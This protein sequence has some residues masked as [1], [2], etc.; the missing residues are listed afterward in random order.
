M[1]K[2]FLPNVTL[3]PDLLLE[4]FVTFVHGSS[5]LSRLPVSSRVTSRGE[6]GLEPLWRVTRSRHGAPELR[7]RGSRRILQPGSPLA[8]GGHYER[9]CLGLNSGLCET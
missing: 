9:T 7:L 6:S 5:S 4:F 2:R 3:G 8:P 1:R